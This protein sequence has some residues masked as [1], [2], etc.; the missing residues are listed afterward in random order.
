MCC[1][2]TWI[3]RNTTV[4]KIIRLGGSHNFNFFIFIFLKSTVIIQRLRMLVQRNIGRNIFML[5]SLIKRIIDTLII[6]LSMEIWNIRI[7]RNLISE[8]FILHYP[9]RRLHICIHIIFFKTRSR[10]V[11]WIFYC[12]ESF[13]VIANF[14]NN[15]LRLWSR[16]SI[17]VRVILLLLKMLLIDI[18][19]LFFLFKNSTIFYIF[20]LK[21]IF[22]SFLLTSYEFQR[23][24]G[25]PD[26]PHH[27]L[28]C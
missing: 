18:I 22:T 8:I 4:A 7:S 19:F 26:L 27:H 20:L 10:S 24:F 3:T 15:L 5:M 6:I 11:I 17:R 2:R 9:F 16:R 23:L 21:L 12:L 13:W 25:V 28:K 1:M 14:S